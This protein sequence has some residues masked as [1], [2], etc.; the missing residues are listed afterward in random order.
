MKERDDLQKG[1]EGGRD[2]RSRTEAAERVLEGYLSELRAMLDKLR[3]RLIPLINKLP[4][5]DAEAARAMER[6]V[7]VLLVLG[8]T[9]FLSERSFIF[10]IHRV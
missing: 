1:T 8:P 9:G 6:N 10:P 3:R 7:G 2:D 5:G 4:R